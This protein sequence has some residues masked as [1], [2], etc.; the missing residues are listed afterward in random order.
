MK[1][2]RIHA[3]AA[4]E[5][6]AAEDWYNHERPGLGFELHDEV[7]DLLRRVLAGAAPGVAVPAY[8]GPNHARRVLMDRFPFSIV[9][10]EH[11]ETVFVVAFAHF[12]RRPGYWR[13][14]LGAA[15]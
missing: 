12:R 9:F 14:R 8:E 15:R 11:D 6:E 1:Q 3:A 10:L 7:D 5:L 2:L 4:E 13:S